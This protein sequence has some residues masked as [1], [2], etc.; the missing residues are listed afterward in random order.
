MNKELL[1]PSKTWQTWEV[2]E[3]LAGG[4]LKADLISFF[5]LNLMSV[6]NSVVFRAGCAAFNC[7]LSTFP[8]LII[9]LISHLSSHDVIPQ[10]LT[11]SC[12]GF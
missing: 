1:R 6:M 2:E 12:D 7:K 9:C 4:W 3:C 10:F 11:V 8:F 5:N